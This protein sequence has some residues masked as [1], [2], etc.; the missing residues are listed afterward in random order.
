[1]KAAGFCFTKLLRSFLD[2]GFQDSSKTCG[3]FVKKFDAALA[4]KQSKQED[5]PKFATKNTCDGLLLD[6][7]CKFALDEE[8]CCFCPPKL[9]DSINKGR[10]SSYI[11]MAET[12]R[13]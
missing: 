10:W 1:M 7:K 3:F 8:L 4:F 9:L 11:I 5:M 12:F 13:K 2:V 6:I